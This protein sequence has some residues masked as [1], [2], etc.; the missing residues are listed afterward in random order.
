MIFMPY[1]LYIIIAVI[2][3]IILGAIGIPMAKK[4]K[5]HQ[6]IREEG[7]KSHRC[8]SGTPTMGGLFMVLA[9]VIVTVFSQ[10]HSW[11]VILFVSSYCRILHSWIS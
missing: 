4:Y 3:T 7:P 2:T 1:L 5:A 11:A 6:S 9:A 10:A 8:K